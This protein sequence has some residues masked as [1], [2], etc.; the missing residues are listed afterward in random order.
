MAKKDTR[1]RSQ[2]SVGT[3]FS[4]RT[5]TRGMAWSVPVVAVAAHA[6]A[7]AVSRTPP[8]AVF[9][10]ACK[11]PGN[12]C[13][14]AP[15]GYAFAFTV[16]NTDVRSLAFCDAVLTIDDPNPFPG[17]TFTYTN[18][19]FTL[20]GGASG[21][22]YFFF[23]GSTDSANSPFTG[24]I[25]LYYANDCGDCGTDTVALAPIPITVTATPPGGLCQCEAD[26]IPA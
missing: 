17:V 24:S 8:T 6:P 2:E 18:E 26:F 11:Y 21:T 25:T 4:R 16:T 14:R 1:T 13:R 10:G 5:L 20:G 7:F 22:A 3:P 15:K 9:V 12:S 19:C 23:S